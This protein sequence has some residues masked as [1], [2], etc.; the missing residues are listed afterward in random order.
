MKTEEEREESWRTTVMLKERHLDPV[1][2]DGYF[3]L[4]QFVR[5]KLDEEFLD[6]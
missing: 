1:K 6:D 4:S 3:N 2:G 5:E